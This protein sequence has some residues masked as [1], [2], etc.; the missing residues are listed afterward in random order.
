VTTVIGTSSLAALSRRTAA[1][2]IPPPDGDGGGGGGV[3]VDVT[4]T[5]GRTRRFN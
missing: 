3:D 4:V 2:A 1:A 5:P